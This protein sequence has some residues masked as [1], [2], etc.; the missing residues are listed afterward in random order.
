MDPKDFITWCDEIELEKEPEVCLRNVASRYYY[1][2]FHLISDSFEDMPK[3]TDTGVHNSVSE[4]LER[5]YTG[6]KYDRNE[7]KKLSYMMRQAKGLRVKADYTLHEAFTL[8][9]CAT[10]KASVKKCL[11]QLEKIINVDFGLEVSSG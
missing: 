3:Y 7:L 4:Y 11:T 6:T 10:T 9:D 2:L 1:G 8:N 5:G